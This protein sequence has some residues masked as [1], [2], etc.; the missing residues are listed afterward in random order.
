MLFGENRDAAFFIDPDG[1]PQNLIQNAKIIMVCPIDN[2]VTREKL[3]TLKQKVGTK[4]LLV[5]TPQGFFRRYNLDTSV[6]KGEWENAEEMISYFD[7]VFLSEEDGKMLD[8]KVVAW[9]KNSIVVLTRAE[10]GCS[11]FQNGQR[12]DFP[13]FRVETIVDPVGAG[14]VF[15]AAFVYRYLET[16]DV[17]KSAVFANAAAA[18]SLGFH[19]SEMRFTQ[20]D[21]EQFLFSR[22]F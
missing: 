7:L 2:N 22:S 1:V 12:R 13:A 19:A 6:Y 20:V 15:A 17:G 21:I 4:T 14:D 11:V 8:E 16:K 3:R 10:R 18:L 9:S 5:C